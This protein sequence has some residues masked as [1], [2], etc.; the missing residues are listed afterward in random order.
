MQCFFAKLFSYLM[1]IKK[2]A[3]VY[4]LKNEISEEATFLKTNEL[5]VS[6]LHCFE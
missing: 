4:H 2:K 1:N 3:Q 6:D 5:H